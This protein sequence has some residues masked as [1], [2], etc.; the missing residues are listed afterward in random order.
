MWSG[1]GNCKNCRATRTIRNVQTLAESIKR[2]I[3][4]V[5]PDGNCMFRSI[6]DQLRMQVYDMKNK[7]IIEGDCKLQKYFSS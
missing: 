5:I 7:S 3:H 6:I 2:E 1:C 4:D